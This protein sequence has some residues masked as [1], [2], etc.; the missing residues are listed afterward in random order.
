MVDT[1]TGASLGYGYIATRSRN[2]FSIPLTVSFCRFA[3]AESAMTAIQTMNGMPYRNKTLLCKLSN[4][5]VNKDNEQP[6]DNL[7]VRPLLKSTSE[8]MM[9]IRLGGSDSIGEGADC[10]EFQG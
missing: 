9:L 1:Q 10:G 6:Q 2:S 8:S 5:T 4:P 3:Q 7:Y